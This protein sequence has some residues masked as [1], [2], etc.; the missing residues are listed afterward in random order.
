MSFLRC[1]F[2]NDSTVGLYNSRD[3]KIENKF[4]AKTEEN[5]SYTVCQT[6]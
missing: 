6:K 5:K 2:V 4:K 3:I 1:S